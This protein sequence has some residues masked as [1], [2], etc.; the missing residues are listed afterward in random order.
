MNGI[1]LQKFKD[2]KPVR[3]FVFTGG[4]DFCPE[5]MTD[6]PCEG[7]LVI[8]ADSGCK[9]VMAF[10]SA[11]K[12]TVPDIIVGD[13]DSYDIKNLAASFPDSEFFPFPPEKD[14]TDTALAVSV[15]LECGC[16]EIV[17]AGGL[18][19]RLDHT[20]AN[21]FLLEHIRSMGARCVITDGKNRAYLAEN[22]NIL[23]SCADEAKNRKYVSLIPFDGEV[24]DV[25]MDENFKYPYTAKS[26]ERRL[27]V[28]VSNEIIKYPAKI[29]VGGGTALIAECGE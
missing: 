15:A 19:G 17:I 23:E 3:A 1:E 13:M 8:A 18:G 6:I 27:F 16:R 26:I 20:F 25:I 4:K 12:E 7:D 29:I 5:K 11:V 24:Y 2:R 9:S 22:E 21:V 28:T 14:Y 10:S